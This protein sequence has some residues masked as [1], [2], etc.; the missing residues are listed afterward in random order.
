MYLNF[1]VYS[2]ISTEGKNS[3]RERVEKVM[4]W[5]SRDHPRWWDPTVTKKC[6]IEFKYMF[7]PFPLAIELLVQLVLKMDCTC[8]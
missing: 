4:R 7:N 8:T 1:K 3:I 6:I 2:L 5:Q